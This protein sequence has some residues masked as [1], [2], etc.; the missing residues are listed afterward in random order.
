MADTMSDSTPV[1]PELVAD[2]VIVQGAAI[3]PPRLNDTS[4]TLL[5]NAVAHIAAQA[6]AF[7][8]VTR[9]DYAVAAREV[10]NIRKLRKMFETHWKPIVD[11]FTEL[12]AKPRRERDQRLDS[13]EGSLREYERK[14]LAF[15][16]DE[17]AAT[18]QRQIEEQAVQKRRAE[19]Q[20]L[21][22]AEAIAKTRGQEAAMKALERPLH[23]APTTVATNVP[24]LAGTGVHTV[25]RKT[26]VGRYAYGVVSKIADSENRLLTDQEWLDARTIN[27]QD[28]EDLIICVG[29][30]LLAQRP[31]VP[32]AV[33]EYLRPLCSKSAEPAVF[34]TVD[35]AFI[36]REFMNKG[37]SFSLGGTMVVLKEG[38]G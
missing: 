17:D 13:L 27:G 30:S 14:M 16:R 19:E 1:T 38:L 28:L 25:E 3:T 26:V 22:E 7:I 32:D 9:A 6:G 15:K 20:R 18:R 10:A 2:V 36:K 34:K 33:L 35:A 31:G 8:C 29:A 12:L 23:I 4:L 21:A 5:D 11:Y 37:E 24:K